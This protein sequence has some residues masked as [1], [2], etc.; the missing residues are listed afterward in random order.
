MHI[1]N[2]ILQAKQDWLEWSVSGMS[3]AY[4]LMPSENA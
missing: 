1:C 4:T 3:K 2:L